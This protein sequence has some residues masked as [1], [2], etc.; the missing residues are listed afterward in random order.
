MGRRPLQS[1]WAHNV[2][3]LRSRSLRRAHLLHT[4]AF[5][6]VSCSHSLRSPLDGVNLLPGIPSCPATA[7]DASCWSSVLVMRLVVVSFVCVCIAS[8]LH[9]APTFA[10]TAPGIPTPDRPVIVMGL[11]KVGTSS[12]TQ[13]F[14]C[15]N[16]HAT[17]YFCNEPEDPKKQ[18]CSECVVTSIE[19]GRPPLADC[20]SGV[21][22]WG[23]LDSTFADG[24]PSMD[25]KAACF[26]PQI[27]ALPQLALG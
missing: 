16:V 22:V 5:A 20:P 18:F 19:H 3:L 6:Q 9:V 10:A 7:T 26:W 21:A 17:H 15:G 11:P 13:F 25:P 24:N 1:L 27:H 2:F 8:D 12:I 23:E 14:K 4:L